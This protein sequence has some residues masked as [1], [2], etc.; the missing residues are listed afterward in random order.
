[1]PDYSSSLLESLSLSA[2]TASS[3]VPFGLFER[4]HFRNAHDTTADDK[5][6]QALFIH[7]ATS[8]TDARSCFW[9]IE[10][11]RR[12]KN[13]ARRINFCTHERLALHL[14]RGTPASRANSLAYI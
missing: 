6:S 12:S 13:P 11:L 7:R 9:Q 10:V 4:Q 2:K 1:M 5:A 3:S 8:L 14:P